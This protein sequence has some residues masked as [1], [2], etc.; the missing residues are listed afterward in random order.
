[1]PKLLYITASP[2]GQYSYSIRAADA[3]LEAYRER[4]ADLSVIRRDLFS[5]EPVPFAAD[6]AA[7]KYAILHGTTAPAAAQTAFCEVEKVIE[8][9]V[10]ADVYLFAVP[11]WN[12][13]IPYALKHYFDV[14]VQPTYTFAVTDQGYAGLVQGKTAVTVYARGGEYSTPDTAGCDLQKPYVELI[15]GFMGIQQVHP[16]VVEPTLAAGPDVAAQKLDAALA[17]ARAL[18]GSLPA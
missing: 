4:Q 2:R 17:E 7:G 11:M 15:L 16:V 12:F 1:M 18:A 13:G 10:S 8:E 5:D 9:F 14:I 3:F 6:A